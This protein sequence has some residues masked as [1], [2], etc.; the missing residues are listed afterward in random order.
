MSYRKKNIQLKLSDGIKGSGKGLM[1]VDLMGKLHTTGKTKETFH[2]LELVGRKHPNV[3]DSS[4]F[5]DDYESSR[6]KI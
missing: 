3:E 6:P 1:T 5:L 2:K 4:K